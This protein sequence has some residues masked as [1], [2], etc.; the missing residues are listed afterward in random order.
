MGGDEQGNRESGGG[1]AM[2]NFHGA[3]SFMVF[4]LMKTAGR[5]ELRPG[6]VSVADVASGAPDTLFTII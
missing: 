3:I 5:M 4:W 2:T 1:E 6:R